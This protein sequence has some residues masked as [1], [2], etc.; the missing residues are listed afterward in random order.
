[1]ALVKAAAT[2]PEHALVVWRHI[3]LHRRRDLDAA[4]WRHLAL[5]IARCS[6]TAS[7]SLLLE[8]DHP[9]WKALSRSTRMALVKAAATDPEHALVVWRHIPPHR[10]RDLDAAMWRRLALGIARCSRTASQC[11][12]LEDDHPGWKALSRSTRMALVKAAATDPEHALEVWRHIPPHRQR[13]LDA[14]MWRHLALGGAVH[15]SDAALLSFAVG[16]WS[17][18][19]AETQAQIVIC[20][21]K[22]HAVLRWTIRLILMSLPERAWMIIVRRACRR[23]DSGATS[24]SLW[25]LLLAPPSIWENLDPETRQTLVRRVIG[26]RQLAF[27]AHDL[28]FYLPK[29]RRKAIDAAA[30][31]AIVRRFVAHPPNAASL[32]NDLA[33]DIWAMIDRSTHRA[34]ARSAARD[35]D[36]ARRVLFPFADRGCIAWTPHLW[37]AIVQ[38]G[39]GTHPQRACDVACRL[40][41]D[42]WRLLGA[43]TQRRLFNLVQSDQE[44]SASVLAHAPES[45]WRSRAI[46]LAKSAGTSISIDAM[47]RLA[48]VAPKALRLPSIRRK[49]LDL[50]RKTSKAP[51]IITLIL[52]DALLSNPPDSPARRR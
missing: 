51:P 40:P 13:D 12:L 36:V 29:E 25:T 31:N 27:M 39:V 19:D 26:S 7:R 3:P 14:A 35:E 44:A 49:A 41:D 23:P 45:R 33:P 21:A 28:L 37:R 52:F 15:G 10:P 22:E 43:A 2:D 48:R 17:R 8:D 47:E 6:G 34:I 1:M 4:M 30:W 16:H 24:T 38:M 11:L 46:T 5:G 20:L 50:A 18:L 42:A 32:I 9:G